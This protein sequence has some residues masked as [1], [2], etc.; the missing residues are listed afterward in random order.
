M[1]L[2]GVIEDATSDVER[3][4]GYAPHELI[5]ANL[6]NLLFSDDKPMADHMNEMV[7][8]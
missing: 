5:G 7:R 3:I 2:D 8:A 6:G 1:Q 4:L